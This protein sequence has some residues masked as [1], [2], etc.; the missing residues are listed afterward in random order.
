MICSREVICG[1]GDWSKWKSKE[2]CPAWA[3][4]AKLGKEGKMPEA[5]LFPFPFPFPFAPF[6]LSL[7]LFSVSFSRA[8][9]IFC[10]HAGNA[11]M[12]S[13]DVKRRGPMSSFRSQF[14]FLARVSIAHSVN[15]Q[16]SPCRMPTCSNTSSSGTLEWASPVCYCNSLT[17][18]S[19]LSMI[20]L[21]VSRAVNDGERRKWGISG[22]EFGAR[23]VTIDGKQ[24]KLQIW[25]TAG[26]SLIRLRN[27]R[28]SSSF[29]NVSGQE[30]FRSI[31]RSYYRGAAGA[32][33]VYDITRFIDCRAIK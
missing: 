8:I 30:S 25:D 29:S 4:C 21:S 26:Q 13:H 24:I 11:A 17:N 10:L 15:F 18:G 16:W 12:Q 3:A 7:S 27:G 22:V 1:T 23:M 6:S 28:S 20:W 33:L 2:P 32:L 14:H 5:I 19:N 9:N 31:T